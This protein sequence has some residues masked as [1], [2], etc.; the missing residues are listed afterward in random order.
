MVLREFCGRETANL[1]HR[2][3]Y[4]REAS[5]R[6][7]AVAAAMYVGQLIDDRV[8]LGVVGKD[9]HQEV[10]GRVLQQPLASIQ[11]PARLR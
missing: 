10:K 6:V 5:S 2:T 8:E 4:R 1:W 7:R 3:A 9:R 11:K